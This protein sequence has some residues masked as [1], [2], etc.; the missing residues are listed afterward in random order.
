[1]TWVL[2]NPVLFVSVSIGSVM[3][4]MLF[5]ILVDAYGRRP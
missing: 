4:L 5:D 3:L 1:M 2:D